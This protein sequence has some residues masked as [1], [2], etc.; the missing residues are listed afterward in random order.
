LHNDNGTSCGTTFNLGVNYT[1][2]K[3][4]HLAALAYSLKKFGKNIK[5]IFEQ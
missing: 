5:I 4:L 1:S 2:I 3:E